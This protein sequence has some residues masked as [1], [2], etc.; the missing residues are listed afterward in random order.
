[1]LTGSVWNERVKSVKAL[2]LAKR[3]WNTASTH[4]PAPWGVSW[5]FLGWPDCAKWLWAR[6]GSLLEQ[7]S[8]S[9]PSFVQL[10]SHAFCSFL[11]QPP[12]QQP[13]LPSNPLTLSYHAQL[14]QAESAQYAK[15]PS[16][17]AFFSQRQAVN[18]DA[19]LPPPCH[20]SK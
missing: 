3:F 20:C 14:L 13:H 16:P 8:A 9:E 2:H 7:Q 18:E 10:P 5:L 15:V 1:M 12:P 6:A 17:G 19:F 11:L 4:I